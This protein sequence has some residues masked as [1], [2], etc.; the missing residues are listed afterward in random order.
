MV[1]CAWCKKLIE[2]SPCFIRRSKNNFCGPE[3]WGKWLSK[4]AKGKN[5]SNWRGG[6]V[7]V[8]CAW[9]KKTVQIFPYE[10]K[11][12][13]KFFC[14][15]KCKA[16]WQSM[17]GLGENNPSWIDG[18]SYIPYSPEFNKRLK[19]SI[20]QR[21]NFTCQLCKEKIIKQTK[22]KFLSIHHIDY[23]KK[24]NRVDNLISL[25]SVCNSKVNCNREHWTNHFSK[26]TL[27]KFSNQQRIFS[28]SVEQKPWNLFLKV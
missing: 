2:K 4:Y 15:R 7:V 23:N 17:N 28:N 18:R 1:K 21:D 26:I 10:H 25:C 19:Q 13:R 3:C 20:K 27:D 22:G 9:C 12:N 11:P 6:P 24:N 16:K 14:N 8:K 5:N